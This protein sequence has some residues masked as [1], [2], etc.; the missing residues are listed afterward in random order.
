MDME[1][2]AG[3]P[4][5]VNG[6][7]VEPGD[8]L[9]RPQLES[10]PYMESYVSAGYIYPVYTKKDY[11]RLPPHIFTTVMQ[12][13]EM[14]AAMAQRTAM[15]PEDIAAAQEEGDKD[16]SRILAAKEAKI[17]AKSL[18]REFVRQVDPAKVKTEEEVKEERAAEA[19]EIQEQKNVL[20]I[21]DQTPADVKAESKA[22]KGK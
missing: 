18:V 15:V 12:R 14:E 22:P 16:E 19:K 9:T 17:D 1:Y 21:P 8:R 3:R 5:A 4:F 20:E 11:D 10:I 2:I 7:Y 13:R 6:D